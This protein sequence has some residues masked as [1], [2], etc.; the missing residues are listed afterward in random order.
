MVKTTPLFKW[1]ESQKA[2]FSNF[3]G[4]KM[5][6]WYK[7]AKEEHLAVLTKAG[8]FDTSHMGSFK[9]TGKDARILLNQCFSRDFERCFKG[10]PLINFRLVYGVFISEKG[11]VI[12]D[13]IVYQFG[14]NFY[15]VIVNA[16]KSEKIIN[17]IKNYAEELK[18]NVDI[19]DFTDRI[20]KIDVQGPFS[21]LILYHSLKN[22]EEIFTQFP[23]F[24]F[25]GA[26][27][28]LA[29]KKKENL[30]QVELLNGKKILLSRSGYTGE[31]GFEIYCNLEDT[32]EIW[33]FLIEKGKDYGLIPCGLASRDSL[34]TGALLPLS[35]QDIGDWPFLNNPWD[36]FCLPWKEYKKSFSKEF[37]G[38]KA[39][40]ELLSNYSWF[41]YPFVG[42]DVR[43]VNLAEHPVVILEG[44]K[45]GKVLTC[46]TDMGISWVDD[47][48]VSVNSPNKPENF[49]P[50]GLSCGFIL[51][52]QDLP[53]GTWVTLKD[54]KRE[55]PVKIVQDIRP[56]RTA[57]KNL[58]DFLKIKIVK[59][60]VYEEH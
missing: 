16:G 9:V 1:H 6:L 39:L 32:L 30:C 60:E 24:S 10:K 55:I 37:V 34:R 40:E 28:E 27:P 49:K 4:Y 45:I 51:V 19:E 2:I 54:N 8:I 46:C 26:F 21:P 47:K 33:E 13:A 23:Y 48:I 42:K 14:Q 7:S 50:K 52:N 43:K 57:R 5:P 3:N 31:I 38:K 29:G 22:P 11:H 44:K 58:K 25:K 35:G 36:K 20:G 18:L 59:G 41:T 15:Y 53:V 12:D 17:H 56:D